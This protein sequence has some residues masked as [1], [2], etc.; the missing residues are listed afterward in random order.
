MPRIANY[1][2]L[3]ERLA[4]AINQLEVIMQRGIMPNPLQK[5][6]IKTLF[7][8][9]MAMFKIEDPR[10]IDSELGN[11]EKV[12]VELLRAAEDSL[13]DPRYLN[14]LALHGLAEANLVGAEEV[15]DE[16]ESDDEDGQQELQLELPVQQEPMTTGTGSI[17]NKSTISPW[18]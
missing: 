8:A 4:A 3:I 17:L 1:N 7:V 9:L 18:L 12:V 15:I 16:Q 11:Y 5:G 14:I 10:T 2:N 13:Y 6:L